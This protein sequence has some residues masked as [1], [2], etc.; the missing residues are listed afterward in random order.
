MARHRYC[1]SP[2]AWSGFAATQ[3]ICWH[4]PECASYPTLVPGRLAGRLALDLNNVLLE[5]DASNSVQ[6]VYT[7]Q[8]V[9]FGNLIS[10]R[11]NGVTSFYLYDV[12]G[13]TRQLATGVGLVSDSYVYDSYGNAQLVSGGTVNPY[14]YLGRIGYSIGVDLSMIY[15]RT[16]MFDPTSGRFTSR[17]PIGFLASGEN[18]YRYASNDPSNHVDPSGAQMEHIP[19]YDPSKL[20]GMPLI[21]SPLSFPVPRPG[22]VNVFLCC[23]PLTGSASFLPGSHCFIIVSNSNGQ[24]IYYTGLP[25]DNPIPGRPVKS[26]TPT[27]MGLSGAY[28]TGYEYFIS[29]TNCVPVALGASPAVMNCLQKWLSWFNSS[30]TCYYALGP[31]SNTLAYTLLLMCLGKRSIPPTLPLSPGRENAPGWG[32]CPRPPILIWRSHRLC[33]VGYCWK[34]KILR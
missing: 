13:T 6:A 12:L 17:D 1:I 8:P 10:Q 30:G 33:E 22:G 23:R 14:R 28:G 27:I 11:R 26:C 19:V 24:L 9:V 32:P 5:T 2:N 18:A 3:M 29:G 34:S 20:P 7:S 21:K 16:R 31:N 25:N 4:E 15:V